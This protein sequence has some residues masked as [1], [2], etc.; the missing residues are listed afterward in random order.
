MGDYLIGGQLSDEEKSGCGWH[1]A[2][3]TAWIIA[4]ASAWANVVLGRVF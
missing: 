3:L 2:T 4:R 1:F